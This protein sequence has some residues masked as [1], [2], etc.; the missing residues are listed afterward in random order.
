MGVL[1]VCVEVSTMYG[2]EPEAILG[3]GMQVFFKA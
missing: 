1:K 2:E 3:N